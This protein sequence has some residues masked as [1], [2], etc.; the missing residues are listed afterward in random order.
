MRLADE[1]AAVAPLRF[2]FATHQRDGQSLRV[3][4]G[5]PLDPVQIEA[6]FGNLRI[7]YFIVLIVAAPVCWQSAE[8]VTHV[9][10]A[11]ASMAQVLVQ[12]IF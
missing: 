11:D 6:A 10:I 2:A 3:R 8:R 5:Q 1:L 12:A 4:I 9:D 7:V